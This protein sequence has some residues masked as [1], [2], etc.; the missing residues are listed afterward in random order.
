MYTLSLGQF[1]SALNSAQTSIAG[2]Y[3]AVVNAGN[4]L[5]AQIAG[6]PSSSMA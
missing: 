4:I 6:A 3:Q 2:D 5:T 1:Y